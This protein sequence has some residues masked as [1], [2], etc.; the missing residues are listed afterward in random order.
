MTNDTWRKYNIPLSGDNQWVRTTIGTPSLSN[1]TS[2]EIHQ[3]TWDTGFTAYYD[4]LKFATLNPNSLPPGGPLPPSGID[5]N[6]I[7]PKV[8][9][10]VFDPIMNNLGDQ[11][12]HVV[13]L[14]IK[15]F[16]L[17]ECWMLSILV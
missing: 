14:W 13:Y 10:Y 4:G 8:L 16:L 15:W 9:L 2:I 3:D 17:K 1:I 12:Q 11:R 7:Q 5:P 6:V